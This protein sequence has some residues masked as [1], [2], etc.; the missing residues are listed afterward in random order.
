MAQSIKYV[1]SQ[2][3]LWRLVVFSPSPHIFLPMTP[4]Q[5]TRDAV[6]ALMLDPA[7]VA[8][9]QYVIV[10]L[11][12]NDFVVGRPLQPNVKTKSGIVP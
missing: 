2:L 10:D 12:R 6:L 1:F 5:M 7:N 11:R 8:G 9:K 3:V 4:K